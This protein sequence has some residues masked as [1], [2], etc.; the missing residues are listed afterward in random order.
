MVLA[1]TA[2]IAQAGWVAFSIGALLVSPG[3]PW[4]PVARGPMPAGYLRINRPAPTFALNDQHGNR[5]SLDDLHGKVAFLTF[6]FGHCATVCPTVLKNVEAAMNRSR[7]LAPKAIVITLDAWRD[8]PS[9]LAGIMRK[10]NLPPTM[11]LLSGHPMQVNQVLDSFQVGRRRDELT[12]QID[13]A[14]LV[15][16]LDGQGRIA[17]A[18]LNPTV[19]WLA[20]AARRASF[21]SMQD[22]SKQS[23]GFP[24]QARQKG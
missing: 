15:Y 23:V 21:P 11:H 7:A 17:Y 10:W 3:E 4:R 19:A 16:V 13:H 24:E 5:L 22:N 1:T 9:A 12:G 14:A 2:L 6:A 18:L 8:S 20:E